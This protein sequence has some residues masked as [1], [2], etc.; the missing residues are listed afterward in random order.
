MLY[1]RGW[2]RLEQHYNSLT[3]PLLL[4]LSVFTCL[5]YRARLHFR[6]C[7]FFSNGLNFSYLFFT[8]RCRV[9]LRRHRWR[10]FLLSSHSV[11]YWLCG[12]CR[13][14]YSRLSCSGLF[15]IWS[16]RVSL[17]FCNWLYFLFNPCCTPR[18]GVYPFVSQM[19]LLI[20]SCSNMVI[21]LV[22]LLNIVRLENTL[23][24][25]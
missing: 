6:L 21:H 14:F 16:C 1:S 17:R 10:C 22:F 20:R 23:S 5:G 25:F 11:R 7:W 4:L 8:L 2:S 3:I 13:F 24:P 9:G 19:I 12:L 18:L 15:L